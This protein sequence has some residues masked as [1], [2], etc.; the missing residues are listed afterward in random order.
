MV[1]SVHCMMGLD[2]MPSAGSEEM[3][4]EEQV[5][6]LFVVRNSYVITKT[7]ALINYRVAAAA[8]AG[9]NSDRVHW[10]NCCIALVQIRN[11]NNLLIN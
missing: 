10:F 1:H 5:E 7:T 8:T 9:K 2:S 11:Y 4:I 3:S 6:R